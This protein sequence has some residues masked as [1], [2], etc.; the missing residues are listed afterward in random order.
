MTTNTVPT[1]ILASTAPWR[2]ALLRRTGV[3]FQT[4]SPP[5]QELNPEDKKPIDISILHA[6]GKADSAAKVRPGT[7]ILA[8]DQTA[9]WQGECLRKPNSK[10]E[11]IHQLKQLMG[12]SHQLHSAIALH[13]PETKTTHHRVTTVTLTMRSFTDAQLIAYVEADQPLGCVGGYM[14]E[15]RGVTLF[16]SIDCDDSAIVG[17]PIAALCDLLESQGFPLFQG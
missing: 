13:N 8:A 6:I 12:S 7:W 14:F 17:L 16:S 10:D 4:M 3:P 5:Y 9:E 15:K 1:L 11:C 2:A